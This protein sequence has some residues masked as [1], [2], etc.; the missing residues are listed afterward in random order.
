M[1][2]GG[3]VV[4]VSYGGDVSRAHCHIEDAVG[5]CRERDEEESVGGRGDHDVVSIGL[6]LD[7]R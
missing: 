4:G 6:G 5:R 7:M 3:R 1:A 2:W